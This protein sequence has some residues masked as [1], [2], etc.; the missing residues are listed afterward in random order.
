MSAPPLSLWA[1]AFAWTLA[2]EL[3]IYALILRRWVRGG[4]PMSA[5]LIGVNVATHPAL[6]YLAPRFSPYWLWVLTMETG[7]V[8]VEALLLTLYLGRQDVPLPWLRALLAAFVANALSTLLG[9]L[10]L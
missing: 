2:F 9:F 10:V 1:W 8:L 4:W 3:P 7:V 6:W 5:V